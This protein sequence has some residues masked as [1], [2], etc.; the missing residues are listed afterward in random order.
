MNTICNRGRM[1]LL[2]ME[3]EFSNMQIVLLTA[4][5]VGGATVLGALLGL[6][7]KDICSHLLS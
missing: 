4:L 6:L 7:F 2:V 5:G 3:R 1:P